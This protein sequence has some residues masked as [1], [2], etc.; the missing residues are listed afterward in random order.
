MVVVVLVQVQV[1][2]FVGVLLLLF[3]DTSKLLWSRRIGAAHLGRLHCGSVGCWLTWSGLSCG[4][5]L[6]HYG[7]THHPT[8]MAILSYLPSD[9]HS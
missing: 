9:G 8:S 6:T 1:P 7:P 3:K 4:F 2:Y 5:G